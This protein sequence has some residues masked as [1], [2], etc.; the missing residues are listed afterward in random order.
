MDMPSVTVIFASP[1]TSC[2][3]VVPSQINTA[4]IRSPAAPGAMVELAKSRHVMPYVWKEK[5]AMAWTTV[6]PFTP[7][8]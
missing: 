8:K 2:A 3:Y 6:T 7:M 5:C 1:V 4:P